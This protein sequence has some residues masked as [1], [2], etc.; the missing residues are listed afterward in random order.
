MFFGRNLPTIEM[1][2]KEARRSR[3]EYGVEDD[4]TLGY[5]IRV[6][7]AD[8]YLGVIIE[9][10]AFLDKS[11]KTIQLCLEQSTPVASQFV[12][13]HGCV[14]QHQEIRCDDFVV[15]NRALHPYEWQGVGTD[16][17][18]VRF[19]F[20]WNVQLRYRPDEVDDFDDPRPRYLEA[21]TTPINITDILLSEMKID[22]LKKPTPTGAQRQLSHEIA[23]DDDWQTASATALGP[24]G[25]DVDEQAPVAEESTESTPQSAQMQA[26]KLYVGP[27]LFVNSDVFVN[28]GRLHTHMP[29][30]CS[31]YDSCQHWWCVRFERSSLCGP[32]SISVCNVYTHLRV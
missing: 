23:T 31:W 13:V 29:L 10:D 28:I 32:F 14:V 16:E 30:E 9:L 22:A 7:H 11:R 20:A 15:F 8:G 26:N 6:P 21:D 1:L 27:P 25:T 3:Q 17:D 18:V 4:V 2:W 5:V 19:A 12:F 24:D